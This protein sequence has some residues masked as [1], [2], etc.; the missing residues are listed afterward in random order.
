MLVIL[1]NFSWDSAANY[2]NGNNCFLS[3]LGVILQK[4]LK[5]L[6]DLDADNSY[7]S[8]RFLS[9]LVAVILNISIRFI[10]TWLLINQTFR[11]DVCWD[12]LL[13]FQIF[14]N[15]LCHT[16]LLM[17]ESYQA[18][19]PLSNLAVNQILHRTNNNYFTHSFDFNYFFLIT[20]FNFKTWHQQKQFNL[21]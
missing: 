10:E 19:K 21:H 9:N 20:T 3:Y 5:C 15:V 14:R 12:W 6:S 18:K 17:V 1:I 11:T 8:K 16:W 7:I 13:I 4:Y 2:S